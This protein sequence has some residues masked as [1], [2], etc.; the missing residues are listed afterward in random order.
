MWT[1]KTLFE[2]RVKGR[3]ER[4]RI[5]E[6]IK[7]EE[8]KTP[9]YLQKEKWLWLAGLLVVVLKYFG[10]ELPDSVIDKVPAV[11]LGVFGMLILNTIL[12]ILKTL[13]YK[14]IKK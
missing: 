7:T 10:I 8:T 1:G 5:M 4:K 2:S 14:Y 12:K 11:E 6:E 13:F 9:W 3:K